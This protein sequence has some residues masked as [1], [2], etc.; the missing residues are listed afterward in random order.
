MIELI[1]G[2]YGVACW[3]V[4]KKFKLIP[5][6]TYTIFSAFLGGGMGLI[7]ARLFCSVP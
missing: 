5:V 3:L 7:A 6:N 1:V 4:F 2:T